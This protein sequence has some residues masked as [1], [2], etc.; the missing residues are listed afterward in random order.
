M[1]KT[2]IIGDPHIGKGLSIGKPGIGTG[3]NSRVI[4]QTKILDWL[5]DLAVENSISRFIITGDVFEDVKPDYTFV[6]ILMSWLKSCELHNIAVDI[7][8][9]NHDLRRSGSNYISSLDVISSADLSNVSV[10]KTINTIHV[11]G[12]SFTLVPFRDRRSLNCETATEALEKIGS[13]L[14]YELASIPNHH[15]KIVVGHLALEGSLP[16]GDEFDDSINELLCPLP[17]FNGYDY[18]WMGHVHRPHALSKSPYIAHIG[19]LDLSDFGETD[20]TKIVVLY[21]PESEGKF[22]EINVPSRPLRRIK[23]N[24]PSGEDSTEFSLT[25]IKELDEKT[26][27]KNAIVKVDIKIED[28]E[29]ES[30]DKD[31]IVNF[32][33]DCGAYFICNF[34]ESKNVFVVSQEKRDLI[35][36]TITPKAAIK[37]W[38]NYSKLDGDDKSNFIKLATGIVDEYEAK[39]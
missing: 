11:D 12:A 38:A 21:D 5:I 39:Q 25:K 26:K 7:I 28:H 9:G 3:L 37:L 18:V 34:S 33:N 30:L 24:V 16:I 6:V 32:I 8:V 1:T 13:V 14:S 29:A 15:D 2:L 23:F 35:E 22:K 36:N 10:H 31:K 27:L 4:D 20:H 19:S 17:M